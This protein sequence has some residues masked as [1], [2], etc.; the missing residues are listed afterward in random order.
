MA[1][2]LSV[3]NQTSTSVTPTAVKP[4]LGSKRVTRPKKARVE[5][6][7]GLDSSITRNSST[8]IATPPHLPSTST[9]CNCTYAFRTALVAAIEALDKSLEEQGTSKKALGKRKARD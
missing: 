5:S 1:G 3:A 4:E 9:S 8:P 6:S 7:P 2:K